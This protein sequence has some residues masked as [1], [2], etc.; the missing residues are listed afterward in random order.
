LGSCYYATANCLP[1]YALLFAYPGYSALTVHAT[2]NPTQHPKG[3]YRSQNISGSYQ[4]TLDARTAVTCPHQP[5]KF[6]STLDFRFLVGAALG[7]KPNRKGIL[8]AQHTPNL[9]RLWGS[10]P[11]EAVGDPLVAV[12]GNTETMDKAAVEK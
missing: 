3:I 4:I 5:I 8:V 12:Y 1:E 7:G 9:R 11:E 2:I 6:R 10:A